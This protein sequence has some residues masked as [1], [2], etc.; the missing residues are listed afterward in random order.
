MAINVEEIIKKLETDPNAADGIT[1]DDLKELLKHPYFSDP[2]YDPYPP[3]KEELEAL[4]ENLSHEEMTEEEYEKYSADFGPMCGFC[5][6]MKE[7]GMWKRTCDAF[8]DGI[9]ADIL[10]GVD[11]RKAHEGDNGIQFEVAP[12]D[13]KA[14][15]EWMAFM[16]G[17]AVESPKEAPKKEEEAP[18]EAPAKE[19]PAKEE[20]KPIKSV[21]AKVKAPAPT[22]EVKQELPKKV[23]GK[24][25]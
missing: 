21:R 4:K 14:F 3:T 2:D 18:E 12:E 15:E 17:S 24:S 10:L 9:P 20:E 8:P 25:K 22:T 11:H 13:K 5:T 16:E 19:E 7:Y 1:G 23:V 6:H